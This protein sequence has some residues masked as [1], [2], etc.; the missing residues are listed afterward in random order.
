[1]SPFMR[2]KNYVINLQNLAYISVQDNHIDFGFA[3]PLKKPAGQNFIRFEKGTD[4]KDAEFEEV[5]EFVL[6]LPDPDRVVAV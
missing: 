3:F 1:M 2:V 4:L 5:K 6:Q